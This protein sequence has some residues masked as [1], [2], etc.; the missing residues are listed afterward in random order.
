MLTDALQVLDNATPPQGAL[1]TSNGATSSENQRRKGKGRPHTTAENLELSVEDTAAQIRLE[2]EKKWEQKL[3][4]FE[5]QMREERAQREREEQKRAREADEEVP[6]ESSRDKIL[7][8]AAERKAEAKNLQRTAELARQADVERARVAQEE[9]ERARA[10]LECL[11]RER[12][13]GLRLEIERLEKER[14]ERLRLE[15]EHLERARL[16]QD[17]LERA[18]LEAERLEQ[19]RLEQERLEGERLERERLERE[20]LEG[21]RLE[22]L[23]LERLEMER[24][25]RERLERERLERQRL[26]KL[27]KQ[28]VKRE[29]LERERAERER[30]AREA[31]EA[32]EKK[33]R[34]QLEAR[35]KKE[36]AVTEQCVV[37]DYSLVTCGAGLDIQHIV[38]GFELCRITIKNLPKNATREEIGNLF[39]Q[40][41]L[42]NSHF[43]VCGLRDVGPKREGVV[44]ANAEKCQA[45]ITMGLE[46]IRLRNEIVKFEVTDNASA[47]AMNA[48]A[49]RNRPFL[50]VNWK[51]PSDII[52][53]SYS[54]NQEARKY[55]QQLNSP[56][57][58]KDYTIEASLDDHPRNIRRGAP[59]A[60]RTILKLS[61][62]AP[63]GFNLQ[64]DLAFMKFVGT[65]RLRTIKAIPYDA[66]SVHL[67]L[68][69][70]FG[71]YN[72]LARTY[73]I[74]TPNATATEQRIKVQFS[75]WEDVIRAHESVHKTKLIIRNG[76]TTPYLR[77]WHPEP[78]QYSIMIPN[79]QYEAQKKQWDALSEKAPGRDAY[80]HAR[81]GQLGDVFF[82]RVLG[83]D[84]KAA[85]TLKVRVENMVA[86]VA[87]DASHWHP[88]FMSIARTKP[89]FD[90]IYAATKVHIR[91]DFK[92]R[93]LNVYGDADNINE[94]RRMVK[95]EVDRLAEMETS[96]ILDR[97]SVRFFV[98][99]GLS[100]LK[101]LVGDDNVSL[102]LASRPCT[103]TIKGGEEA[104]HHLQR[105][106]DESRS[107]TAL[108]A[109]IPSSV[110]RETCPI[111]YNGVSNP[112]PLGCGHTYCSGCLRHFLASATDT[113]TFPLVCMGNEASCNTPISIPLIQR[114]LPAQAFYHLVE[115]AFTSYLE[116]HPQ[117]L[118][119]CTTA[120]CKQ[121]YR[122][123]TDKAM[124]QCPSCF[125]EICPACDEE[126]HEGMSCQER[127]Q[128]KDPE[129]QQ[130]LLNEL[131]ASG[132]WKK[133]PQCSVWIEKTEGCNHMECQSC[134]THF[135]WTC[136]GVFSRDEIYHHM[137]SAHGG[138]HDV[139]AGI[140][141][142]DVAGDLFL[143][144]QL[145]AQEE[146]A[147]QQGIA[148]ALAAVERARLE[149]QERTRL[150]Q[151]EQERQLR[152]EEARVANLQ[153]A[154]E[155]ELRREDEERQRLRR[156]Q[157]QQRAEEEERTRREAEERMVEQQRRAEE[158]ERARRAQEAEGRRLEQLRRAEEQDRERRIQ[159]ARQR[160]LTAKEE[161]SRMLAEQARLPQMQRVERTKRAQ[162]YE[163]PWTRRL[164]E[165]TAAQL[166]EVE[167]LAGDQDDHH[168]A[169]QNRKVQSVRTEGLAATRLQQQ[170]QKPDS[171]SCTVM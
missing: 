96:R 71:Q 112:E 145:Q 36:A 14:L 138:I 76:S 151:L 47:N 107:N 53:A 59:P 69:R 67:T 160:Q 120:N 84:K 5:T 119:Y 152:E 24:L 155:E 116:R 85:G 124:L 64:C 62:N 169:E 55:M 156:L 153:R 82:I 4:R 83:V 37:L 115:V 166:Q 57:T 132:G 16:E 122:R 125:S 123:Q 2:E 15:A 164:Q 142:Q 40:K 61:T 77:A 95:T 45:V 80:I 158:E 21:E 54:S 33:H 11:A 3:E 118:K 29:R 81:A 48:A 139:P 94:A 136:M 170:L 121:V 74:L 165:K 128:H 38:T 79:R 19:E 49:A 89:L 101:E 171:G 73:E 70:H 56:K 161:Q 35:W 111:C 60:D 13:E 42:P 10:L 66:D 90:R 51:I 72:A 168:R 117:E 129:E 127:R 146:A 98:R 148:I 6:Q 102:N 110:E 86:G 99:E 150:R 8:M 133:C 58:W 25:E 12:E 18:R 137:N 130:R 39:I 88:S 141:P 52:V 159:E 97:G 91:S 43:F 93:S 143:A 92:T 100:K 22:R 114:F 78:L 113:K 126:A 20:R 31:R 104:R 140:G 103:I 109:A 163:A 26:E 134:H 68:S 17:R 167:R 7:R 63:E 108:E 65:T 131:A 41:G 44:L 23:R 28:R 154:A 27:E 149:E 106:I 75:D 87:L 157:L 34:L 1:E 50:N 105:V 144:E 162:N 46:G 147:R 32:A 30:V 9:Q 135:C